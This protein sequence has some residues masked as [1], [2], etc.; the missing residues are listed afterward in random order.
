MRTQLSLGWIAGLVLTTT[1]MASSLLV[2][3]VNG[4]A[5][6]NLKSGDT[7][8]ASIDIVRSGEKFG[9]EIYFRKEA[10]KFQEEIQFR[11]HLFD[12]FKIAPGIAYLEGV[13]LV[14]NGKWPT[15]KTRF[16]LTVLDFSG[17]PSVEAIA[18][19]AD[20]FVLTIFD[21]KNNAIQFNGWVI[22]GDFFV[23]IT[24]P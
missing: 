21:A 4:A 16:S 10:S 19:E 17:S 1:A 2:E 14:G 15:N 9:G 22:K 12:T 20:I 18:P 24:D 23:T 8:Y 7:A 11:A 13:G 6:L 3:R 5:I